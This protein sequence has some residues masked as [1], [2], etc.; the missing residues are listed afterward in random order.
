MPWYIT[1]F[2]FDE[3]IFINLLSKFLADLMAAS[4]IFPM[5]QVQK[6][7]RLGLGKIAVIHF[8]LG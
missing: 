5:I 1:T 3:T 4:M 8:R 2:D 7:R 6:K